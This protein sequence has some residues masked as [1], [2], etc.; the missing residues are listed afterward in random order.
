MVRKRR[1]WDSKY[2]YWNEERE[3]LLKAARKLRPKVSDS[4]IIYRALVIAVDR[5]QKEL[6]KE[7]GKQA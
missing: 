2:L 6:G 5:W 7:Q 4:E 3:E 1:K